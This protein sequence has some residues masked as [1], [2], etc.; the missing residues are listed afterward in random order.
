MAVWVTEPVSPAFWRSLRRLDQVV[1]ASAEAL[2]EGRLPAGERPWALVV[3]NRTR[4]GAPL[5]ARLAPRLRLVAR[6]G[7]GLDNVDLE[8]ARRLGVEVLGAAAENAAAT[9]DFTWLLA[10]AASRR[11]QRALGRSEVAPAERLALAGR[12]LA[13]GTWG[14]VGFGAVGRRVAARAQAWGMRVLALPPRHPAGP[15]PEGVAWS[16]LE[17]L[18]ARSDVVSLHLPLTPETCHLLDRERLA[19][20]RPGSILVNTARGALVDE[21]ALLAALRRGRPAAAALD[22][23]EEPLPD[24]DPLAGHPSVLLTPHVAGWSR[25]ALARIER[26]L[27]RELARRLPA[28]PAAA[29]GRR[30]ALARRPELTPPAPGRRGRGSARDGGGGRL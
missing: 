23:R 1:Y 20:F 8:A 2:A 11:L 18:I 5:L 13:G 26:R 21:E 25:E 6:L 9:A 19:L 14:V 15:P 4:V 22:V 7:S 28:E 24:P 10:L 12:E 17:E 27:L 29:G 3:R 16:G 30:L